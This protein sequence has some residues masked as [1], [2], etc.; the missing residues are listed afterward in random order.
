MPPGASPAARL[1]LLG[2]VFAVAA[3]GLVYELVAGAVSSY[4][5]GDA[6]TQFSLVIGVFLCAMGL[7][8]Y[9][10]Q[11]FK[12]KLLTTFIEVEI[13]IGLVGGLSSIAMYATGAFAAEVFPVV[14]YSLC[15]LVG[16]LIGIEIPLL[17]RI[18]KT[19]HTFSAAVS[20]VLALDSNTQWS[21]NL[22]LTEGQNVHNLYAQ[23]RRRCDA[24]R[25]QH[26]A[27]LRSRQE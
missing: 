13:W 25:G 8:S 19:D 6:V 2:S 12:T 3:C 10:A 15:A 5:L 23:Y 14:F 16:I 7:G 21:Y 26:L 17:I 22:P 4:I 9:L 11:F 27:R 1:V 24:R 20:Q 18:L